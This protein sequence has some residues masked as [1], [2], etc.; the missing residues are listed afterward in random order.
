MIGII[1]AMELE[2]EQLTAA[3][4]NPTV[5]ALAARDDSGHLLGVWGAMSD[6]ERRFLPWEK[7]FTQGLYLAGV[8]CRDDAQPPESWVRWDMP[9]FEYLRIRNDGPEAFPRGL[10][11]LA[12]EGLS[13]VGAVQ[14]YNDLAAGAAYLCYPIRCLKVDGE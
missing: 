5:E 3:M 6:P 2:V 1:G 11:L 14:E 7:D 12:Q 9:G 13:L 8:E 10:E 4:E